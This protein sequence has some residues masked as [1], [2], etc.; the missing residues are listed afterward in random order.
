MAKLCGRYLG[1]ND[2]TCPQLTCIRRRGHSGR[3]DN[4]CGDDEDDDLTDDELSV[5]SHHRCQLSVF[6]GPKPQHLVRDAISRVVAEIRRRRA[7]VTTDVHH[8][9]A[10]ARMHASPPMRSE[11]DRRW[12]RRRVACSTRW[13]SRAIS[14]RSRMPSPLVSLACFVR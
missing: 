8:T 4:T 1:D 14:C 9:A 2:A 7:R 11:H 12:Q 13:T 6:M 5:F 3:C 10:P